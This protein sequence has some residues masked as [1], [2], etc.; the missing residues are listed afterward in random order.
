MS[1]LV[2]QTSV[3]VDHRVGHFLEDFTIAQQYNRSYLLMLWQW[4]VLGEVISHVG[5]ARSPAYFKLVL[6]DAIIDPVEMHVHGF[7]TPLL[8]TVVG[9]AHGSAIVCD[10]WCWLLLVSKFLQNDLYWYRLLSIVDLCSVF[11]FCSTS[12]N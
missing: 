3:N 9:N 8:D 4:K 6:L 7:A 1:L 10:H 2:G 11:S 5:F 12:T